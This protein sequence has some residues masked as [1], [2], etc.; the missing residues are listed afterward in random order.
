MSKYQKD[1][2]ELL[3]NAYANKKYKIKSKGNDL[4]FEKQA[5]L[6]VKTETAWMSPQ[7]NKRYSLGSLWLCLEYHMKNIT[8]SN[9]Y[10]QKAS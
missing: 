4:Y 9:Q 7:T 3:R 8:N 10:M 1:P 2:L 5:K 6:D